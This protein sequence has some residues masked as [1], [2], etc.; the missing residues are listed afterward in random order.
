MDCCGR[1][2]SPDREESRLAS[3]P[4]GD[5][6]A[7]CCGR[8]ASPDREESRLASL[9]QKPRRGRASTPGYP[10]NSCNRAA[11]TATSTACATPARRGATHTAS[12]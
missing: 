12:G 10:S 11:S 6:Q 3:F 7:V 9:P 8:G 2:A 5:G 4:Q 1:G